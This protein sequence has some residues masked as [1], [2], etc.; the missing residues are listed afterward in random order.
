MVFK[1]KQRAAVNYYEMLEH[2]IRDPGFEFELERGITKNKNEFNYSYNWPYDW[3]SLVEMVKL[4]AE[5]AIESNTATT[6]D[7]T[8]PSVEGVPVDDTHKH[9]VKGTT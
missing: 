4:D 5:V 6:T 9:N 3:F 7:P 2:S 1:V 8:Q